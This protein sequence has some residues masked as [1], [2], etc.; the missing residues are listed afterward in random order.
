MTEAVRKR[1][2]DPARRERILEAAATLVA[3]RGYH[4]VA[5]ADIGR[6]AG[7]VGSGLYRHFENKS[8]ILTALLEGVMESLES[9][10]AA[11]MATASDDRT[12]LSELV[13]DHVRTAIEDRSQFG[14]YHREL[15]NL[16][17][18]VARRLRRA[19]RLYIE[20][21]VGVLAPLRPDLTETEARLI[22]HT[23]IGGI[24]SI[25]HYNC[26]VPAERLAPLLTAS[27]HAVLGVDATAA[28]ADRDLFATKN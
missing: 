18:D 1:K 7:I 8:A 26:E 3:D 13:R 23:A 9:H 21:W 4:S 22:V 6:A 17:D 12:A 16:E 19:Q 11:I 2:R 20:Q 5:M 28:S 25:L 27:A 15:H 24:Q 14:L 10:A